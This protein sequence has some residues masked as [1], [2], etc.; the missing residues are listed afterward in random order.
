M[1]LLDTH[2]SL[3][4]SDETILT[5]V[6]GA[7]DII[8]VATQDSVL[9]VAKDHAEKVKQLV[10]ILKKQNR[11]EAT[12]HR[13]MYRPWGFYHGVDVGR[14]I[15]EAH[16]RQ[17]GRQAVASETSSPLGA[18]GRRER[19]GGVTVGDDIT[20]VHEN[21]SI[22]VPIGSTHRLANPGKNSARTDRGPGRQLSWR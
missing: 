20:L 2:N 15:R 16:R 10:D 17:S 3:V 1:V 22:Y 13:R 12:E 14:A 4:F 11:R 18:L 19:H 9:V 5:S 7:E 21:E 6:I 8:V